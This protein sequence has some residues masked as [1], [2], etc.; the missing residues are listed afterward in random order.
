MPG[1]CRCHCCCLCLW[2]LPLLLPLPR[3]L[4]NPLAVLVRPSSS[5]TRAR[6]FFPPPPSPFS[7]MVALRRA[8]ET[9]RGSS[10]ATSRSFPSFFFALSTTTAPTRIPNFFLRTVLLASTRDL[11]FALFPRDFQWGIID[12]N[13][14]VSSPTKGLKTIQSRTIGKGFRSVRSSLGEWFSNNSREIHAIHLSSISRD[15]FARDIA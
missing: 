14:G 1:H 13:R 15:V 5:L 11:P 3:A 10:R 7:S 9:L 8:G 6:L 2:P 4:A 12:D